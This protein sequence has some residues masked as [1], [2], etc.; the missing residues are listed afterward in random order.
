VNSNPAVLY[1]R[2]RPVIRFCLATRPKNDELICTRVDDHYGHCCDEVAGASWD[3]RGR[4]ANC[5]AGHD[6]SEEK[7][8]GLR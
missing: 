5:A 1:R 8:L 6:H 7:G 4:D 3:Y 2:T